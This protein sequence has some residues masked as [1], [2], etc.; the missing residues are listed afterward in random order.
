MA[1]DRI[2]QPIADGIL[3]KTLRYPL[4]RSVKSPRNSTCGSA[5]LGNLD[6]SRWWT[7]GSTPI[8]LHVPHK[9]DPYMEGT[10]H[11]V[12][13]RNETVRRLSFENGQLYWLV[14]SPAWTDYLKPPRKIP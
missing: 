14:D 6:F 2:P 5:E 9:P 11:R 4:R 12:F 3:K 8:Y 13:P 7:D 10:V 1:T